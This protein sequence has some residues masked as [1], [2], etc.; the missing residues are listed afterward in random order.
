MSLPRVRR[1]LE[2]LEG[3]HSPQVKAEVRLNTNESPFEPP[4]AFGIGLSAA[5]A[6]LHLNRYPDRTATAL[7]SAIAQSEGTS[8]ERIFAANGS[9]EVLQCLLLAF[10]GSGRR[11]LVFEPTYA[12][13]AHISR[14]TGTEVVAV[15]R[16]DDFS[17]TTDAVVA[18]IEQFEPAITF[19]CSP[20]NPTGRLEALRTVSAALEATEGLVIVDEAYG[21]FAPE[22]ATSLGGHSDAARLVVTKTFSKTWGLAG[23]RLGYAICDPRV[24]EACFTVALPYHLSSLTQAAGLTVLSFGAEMEAHVTEVVN[25]R[26]RVFAG[27]ASLEVDLWDSH[28]NFILFRPRRIPAGTVWA[29]LLERSILVRDCSSWASLTGCLRVTIGTSQENTRFLEAMKEIT[30]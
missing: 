1:D 9:N 24:V 30:T 12:L 4:A 22:S 6:Q 27:L 2:A 10:G 23:A 7:R 28:A 5:I 14:T 3:Y 11:S 16:A 19:L 15:Q 25:E 20:N 8:V 29:A 17:L 18:A 13:H 21:Q 26:E